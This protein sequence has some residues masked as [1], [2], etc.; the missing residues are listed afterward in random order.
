MSNRV[1]VRSDMDNHVLFSLFKAY[2]PNA[3]KGKQAYLE[4]RH[5]EHEISC[6][7]S[8]QGIYNCCNTDYPFSPGD[9]FLHCSNDIHYFK[10]IDSGEQPSLLVIRFDPR[11]V[12]SPSSE[13]SSTRYLRL[14]TRDSEI[15]RF[16]P[17]SAPA[18]GII[19][20]LL[21]EMFKECR[22]HE[23][24]YDLLVKAKLMAVLA[25]M[26]RHFDSDLQGKS[27]PVANKRHLAQM[28]ESMNYILSHLG[29][30]LTL[31]QLAKQACMSRSYYSTIFKALNG[32]SVWEY[33]VSQRIG[34]AEYRLK[35]TED[36]IMHI[37]EECGF[38]GIANFNRAFKKKTGKTPR[39]YR[40]AEYPSSGA[41]GLAERTV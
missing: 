27:S 26:V 11:F 2:Y 31:D 33:I 9:V 14:F 7:I 28:E 41:A 24:A 34:L 32:V 35:S 36:S 12:W 40:K 38:T 6:I 23:P 18:A 4:H 16:I 37:S 19:G 1:V 13:W 21:Q 29:E 30:Q 25:N 22:D 17:G 8:G 5:T 10:S 15:P 39:E 20:D 3:V